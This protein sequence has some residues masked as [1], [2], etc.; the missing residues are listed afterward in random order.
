MGLEERHEIEYQ[1]AIDSNLKID[2][3]S[4]VADLMDST[5]LRTLLLLTVLYYF[6]LISSK[7]FSRL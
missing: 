6:A 4:N 2:Y 5:H 1:R 3:Q 7:Y